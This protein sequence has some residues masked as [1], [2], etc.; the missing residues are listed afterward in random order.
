MK[1]MKASKKDSSDDTCGVYDDGGKLLYCDSYTSTFHLECP[2]M[3]ISSKQKELSFISCLLPMQPRSRAAADWHAC[4]YRFTN[5][6]LIPFDLHM[7]HIL[8][9]GYAKL[10]THPI[11]RDGVLGQ[12]SH[13]LS[14]L[15]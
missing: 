6:V 14:L 15:S 8:V 4:S 2:T 7:Y 3:A 13:L 11:N 1:K 10:V 12:F 5:P 9:H